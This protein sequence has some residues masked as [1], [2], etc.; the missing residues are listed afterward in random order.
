MDVL[1]SVCWIWRVIARSGGQGING[2]SRSP[3]QVNIRFVVD[4]PVVYRAS[5]PRSASSI[6]RSHEKAHPL[7]HS[8]SKV[9]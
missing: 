8:S 3:R 2:I 4:P 1:M 9:A 5:S 6:A 7:A